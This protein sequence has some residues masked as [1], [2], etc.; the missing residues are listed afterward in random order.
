MVLDPDKLT[1]TQTD[2]LG[3]RLREGRL[4]EVDLRALDSYRRSFNEPYES[5]IEAIRA[6]IGLEPTGRPAKST[7]SIIDKLNRESIRLS[8]M[9]DIAGCRL[10]V[11]DILAQNE[12]VASLRSAFDRAILIDRRERPS[13]GYRAVHLIVPHSNKYV[14]VQIRTALQHVWAEVSE[15]LSDT[16]D[17]SI[18]YGGGDDEIRQ[19]LRR[20]SRLIAHLEGPELNLSDHIAKW[21][22]PELPDDVQGLRDSIVN[23]RREITEILDEIAEVFS[24]KGRDDDLLN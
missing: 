9:Q 22:Y 19:L 11:A 6:H 13:H 23:Q 24:R 1:R 10:I 20:T 2:R 17:I 18:K 7:K 8:Q 14:E 12:V 4:S 16:V 5:V 3:D 21:K 15:K